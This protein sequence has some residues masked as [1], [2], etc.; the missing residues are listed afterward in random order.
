MT[1]SI[2][3]SAS[4]TQDVFLMGNYSNYSII[5]GVV[6]IGKVIHSLTPFINLLS[7]AFSHS[8]TYTQ[9]QA[10]NHSHTH[11]HS[12]EHL[13]TLTHAQ[14]LMLSHTLIH[15]HTYLCTHTQ[16]LMHHSHSHTH[17]HA[18]IFY[19]RILSLYETTQC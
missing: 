13:F 17:T 9:T 18:L 16:S 15:S 2:R 12:H 1:I 5:R 14:A 19:I 3:A 11:S 8:L 7:H 10:H 6:G 4:V